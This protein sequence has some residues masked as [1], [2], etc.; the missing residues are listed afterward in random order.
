MNPLYIERLIRPVIIF[1]TFIICLYM[2][3][4]TFHYIYPFIISIGLAF[5]LQPLVSLVEYYLKLSRSLATFM[6]MAAIFC[7]IFI[8]IFIFTDMIISGLIA[9]ATNL[10]ENIS[11]MKSIVLESGQAFYDRLLIIFPFL[12]NWPL[13]KQ[14]NQFMEKG[15]TVIVDFLTSLLWTASEA[16]SSLS[17][18][19]IIILFILIA[20]YML[21]KDYHLMKM[22]IQKII[23]NKIFR[24]FKPVITYTKQ[25][26]I[27]LLRAQFIITSISSIIIGICLYV[28]QLEHYLT[29]T[30]I[31]FIVDFIPYIGIG[32]VFIPWIFFSFITGQY[33]LTIELAALY[34]FV[35]ILRQLIEPKIIAKEIGIHPFIA[36]SILFIGYQVLGLLGILIT[37]LIL[38]FISA[39]H[40]ASMF[41]ALYDYI[42]KK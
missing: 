32:M 23:P 3:K 9:L 5:F 35:L 14:L 10:P 39:L 22:T 12:E 11:Y 2:F 25:S 33:L 27:G 26:F 6:V 16:V 21:I 17:H 4:V 28:F 18:F 30:A 24:H 37:P 15:S 13:T 7:T 38:I 41:S 8:F 31:I 29:L 42:Y 40:K 34:G 36:L 1:L 19:F 20:V